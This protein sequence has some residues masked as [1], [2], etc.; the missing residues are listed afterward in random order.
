MLPRIIALY[1]P[2]Y[3]PFKEN[4]MWWGKGFTEWTNVGKAKALFK[5]HE[6]PKVPSDL[7]YY[8]L[9]LPETRELQAEYAKRAGIEGFCYYHYWFGGKE[10]MERPLNEVIESKSPDFPFCVCWANESWHNKFWNNDGKIEKKLL[11]EQEYLGEVDNEEHFYRLFDAFCD[12]RYLRQDNRLIFMIYN[13]LSF[14]NVSAFMRQWN[15]LA[16]KNGLNGFYF[17]GYTTNCDAINSILELGFDAVNYNRI[18]SCY[19]SKGSVGELTIRLKRKLF[20]KPAIISYKKCI[21]NLC[22]VEDN[23][24]Y[25][26]PSIIP[27][28]DHTPRSGINGFLFHNSTPDLFSEHVSMVLKS[29]QGKMNRL[30]FLKSWNEWGEGNYMEPDLKWGC[31]YIDTLKRELDKCQ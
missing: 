22:G 26:C 4:D 20:H 17:I 13:P 25:V 5:G 23:E 12:K 14:K 2:Q 19:P 30:V 28:W 3:H 7:G 21:R 31:Q 1:L 29:V 8:D 10:L 16:K 24:E 15:L 6:Q 18:D 9:R 27:N 11:I